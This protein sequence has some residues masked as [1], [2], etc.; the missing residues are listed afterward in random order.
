MNKI[1]VST[2]AGVAV[3][4]GITLVGCGSNS[5]SGTSTTSSATTSAAATTTAASSTPAAAGDKTTINQYITDND[6]AETPIKPDE[7]GTPTFD[8]PFPPGWS[9]AG[10]RTPE[11]AY[12]AIVYDQ[13]EDPSDPPIMYAIASKLTG[14]V[15]AAKVLEYAPSQLQDLPDFTPIGD[16]EKAS[17][18][19]FDAVMYA[20]TY[21]NDGKKRVV[22]QKTVVIP[23]KDALFVL[24]LNADALDGQQSV[25]IDAAKL[26]DEKTKITPPA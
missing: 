17:L 19:G 3:V 8:F 1:T 16:P 9:P 5:D 23:G 12:G 11:W 22:A 15:D 4:L 21:T 7:P 26:I 24:Q 18:S 10:D 2:A 13:P 6:I 14:N 20:G 25:V